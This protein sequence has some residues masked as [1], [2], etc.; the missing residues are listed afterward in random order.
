ML[1]Q[2]LDEQVK[3]FLFNLSFTRVKL[4][5]L[6]PILSDDSIEILLCQLFRVHSHFFVY[7]QLQIQILVQQD[8]D[9]VILKSEF[10]EPSKQAFFAIVTAAEFVS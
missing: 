5:N 6:I 3:I 10:S 8:N 9:A 7:R 4:Q 2:G 1:H